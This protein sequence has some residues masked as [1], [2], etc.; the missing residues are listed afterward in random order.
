MLNKLDSLG[1]KIRPWLLFTA[2]NT[3]NRKLDSDSKTLLDVGC[4]TGKPIKFINRHGKYFAVALGTFAPYLKQCKKEKLHNTYVQGDVRHLPFSD[5]AFDVVLCLEVLEHLERE[6]GKKLLRELERVGC[7]QVIL[8]TPVGN[9]K[10]SSYEGNPHQEHKYIWSPREMKTLGYKVIG[11]GMRNL[12]CKS[13][14]QSVFP[15]PVRWLVDIVWVLAGPFVYY[16]P[17]LAGDMGCIKFC[18]NDLSPCWIE[19]KPI[20]RKSESA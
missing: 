19:K 16:C 4:G 15:R 8:S 13:G 17:T 5:K 18:Q 10:Q 2:L 9:S 1:P 11:V 20:E 6:E 12:S 7:R 14:I 3:V